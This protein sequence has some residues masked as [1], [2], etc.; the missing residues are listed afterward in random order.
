MHV[1]QQIREA[2]AALLTGLATTGARVFQSRL[3]PLRD[4]D[5]PC[6][7]INTDDEEIETQGISANALQER[8]LTLSIRAVAKQSDALDAELDTLLAEIETAL[9][10]STLGGKAESILLASIRIEMN[11]EIEKPVGIATAQYRVTYYTAT[12][13]P[14]TA[15]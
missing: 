8:T 14:G 6:L 11:D 13:T 4:A 10:N 9:G 15:L 5:L 7:L 3:R 12:G 1:R 2:A